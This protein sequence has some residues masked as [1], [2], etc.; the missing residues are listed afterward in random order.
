MVNQSDGDNVKWYSV[1][2][3]YCYASM[4]KLKEA[5]A[6]CDWTDQ[7]FRHNVPHSC[8]L[9]PA[10]NLGLLRTCRQIHEEAYLIPYA[11]NTFAF[12][13]GLTLDL[14]LQR[15]LSARLKRAIRTIHADAFQDEG[16]ILYG[17]TPAEQAAMD[18]QHRRQSRQLS[19]F[20]DGKRHPALLDMVLQLKSM[21]TDV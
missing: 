9:T 4:A 19:M 11:T 12:H 17:V 15:S 3:K 6:R 2:H 13:E 20:W 16:A 21:K 18:R 10:F 7:V 8:N 14:F 1:R 5:W